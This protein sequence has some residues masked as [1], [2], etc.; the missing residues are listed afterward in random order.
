MEERGGQ[1]GGGTEDSGGEDRIGGVTAGDFFQGGCTAGV[2]EF[3]EGEGYLE[4]DAEVGIIREF[5]NAIAE[6]TGCRITQKWFG[7]AERVFADLRLGV[8]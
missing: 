4:A 2:I 7:N 1:V 3:A 6:G 5:Q 8:A